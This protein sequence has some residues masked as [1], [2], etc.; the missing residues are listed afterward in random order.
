MVQQHCYTRDKTEARSNGLSDNMIKTQMHPFCF[1][2]PSKVLQALRL[3]A[4]EFPRVLTVVQFPDGKMLLG[5]T[6][7][8]ESR[9]SGQRPTFFTHNYLLPGL[10]SVSPEAID[11]LLHRTIFLT[12]TEWDHLPELEYLPMDESLSKAESVGPLPFDKVR[13]QQL[14]AALTESVAGMRKVY[15]MLPD[16]E[17]VP[18][19]LMWI[20]SRLPQ[21]AAQRLGFTTYC[22]EPVNKEHL[23]LMFME[24][25]SLRSDDVLVKG[26]FVFDFDSGSFSV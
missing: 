6:I 22:R 17:W 4:E 16:I 14:V 1:Y 26:H 21:T 24:K 23:H 19:L 12:E 2:H 20:Y 5:Q 11:L 3:P 15:V 25:G 9:A 18:P 10:Q 8:V 7:Y 13:T